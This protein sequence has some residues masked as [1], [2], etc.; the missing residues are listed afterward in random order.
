MRW[1]LFRE[2][3]RLFFY[4]EPLNSRQNCYKLASK[5]PISPPNCAAQMFAAAIRLFTCSCLAAAV[6]PTVAKQ[7]R[8]GQIDCLPLRRQFRLFSSLAAAATP[9]SSTNYTAAGVRTAA[10]GPCKRSIDFLSRRVDAEIANYVQRPHHCRR[11]RRRRR[12]QVRQGGGG[13]SGACASLP[14]CDANVSSASARRKHN[15][16]IQ[17]NSS[18]RSERVCGRS[19]CGSRA[20]LLIGKLAASSTRPAP[21]RFNS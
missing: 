6:A 9:P 5:R 8:R 16:L 18:G 17:M 7:L 2:Q 21:P 15:Q 11:H 1:P 3:R 13:R 4:A 10:R 20:Q 14:L 19:I 12:Q